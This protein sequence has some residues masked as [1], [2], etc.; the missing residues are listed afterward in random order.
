MSHIGTLQESSLH[1]SLKQWVAQP[2]DRLEEVVDGFVIDICRGDLLIEIQTGNFTAVKQKINQLVR[3][4]AVH[5]VYPMAEAKWI[6]RVA[7]DGHTPI[8]RRKSPKRGTFY[9]LFRQLVRLPTLL[10]EPN[11]SLELLLVQMEEVWCDDGRGSWRR[12]KWSII[13]RR[14]LAV[15]GRLRLN[16]GAE[17]AEKLLPAGLHAPFSSEQL[18]RAIDRPRSLAQQMAYCLRQLGLI[19]ISGKKG[20][21]LLYSPVALG[22]P[23]TPDWVQAIPATNKRKDA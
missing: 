20:N 19:E 2:G 16:N 12:R 3:R 8:S 17:L 1:A 23:E 7:A 9:D 21:A 6:V 11:F 4:H 10:T 22:T 18:A 13:D 15:T 5:L 14:L